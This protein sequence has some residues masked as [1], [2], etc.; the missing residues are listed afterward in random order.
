MIS[1]DK[2]M[3]S[4]ALIF[5][6]VAGIYIYRLVYG[7]VTAKPDAEIVALKQEIEALKGQVQQDRVIIKEVVRDAQQTAVERITVMPDDVVADE[8]NSRL[9]E[10]RKRRDKAGE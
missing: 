4:V 3:V 8:L 1:R 2:I 6:V 9:D 10:Y 7:P 5:L